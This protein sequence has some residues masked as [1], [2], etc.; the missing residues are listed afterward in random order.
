MGR[1]DA[2]EFARQWI[3]CWNRGDVEAVLGHFDEAVR[4]T[5]P[6]A[7]AV[8]G[9]GNVEGRAELRSYWQARLA[10]IDSLRFTLERVLWDGEQRTMAI[11]YVADLNGQRSRACEFLRFGESGTA[12][13]GAAMYGAPL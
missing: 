2:I 13:E 5:S 9:R 7:I 10:Q 8:L 4:F 12:V 1:E 11:L 3:D 6:K